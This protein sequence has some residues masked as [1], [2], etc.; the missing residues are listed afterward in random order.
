MWCLHEGLKGKLAEIAQEHDGEISVEA[1][2]LMAQI[3][4]E[5]NVHLVI[6]RNVFGETKVNLMSD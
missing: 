1:R 6:L 4:L 2:G 5:F 3:D